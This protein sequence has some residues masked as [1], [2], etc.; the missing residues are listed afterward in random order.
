MCGICGIYAWDE[1]VRCDEEVVTR[2]RDTLEHRGPDDAGSYVCPRRRVALGHRRLS[3]ID[4][5]SAGHQPMTSEDE[6]V[7]IVFNGEIY[8]HAALRLELEDRGHVFAS[9]TDTEAI[10]HLYEEVGERCVERLD[11]MFALAIWDGRRQ[12]LFLARDR[13]GVKPLYWATVPGGLLFGSEVKAILEHPAVARGLDEDAFADYLTFGFVP[14]PRTL[15]QG[16]FKLAG[17]ERMTIS[18]NGRIRSDRWWNPFSRSVADDVA[19]AT[20]AELVVALRRL[21]SDSIRQRMMSDVP[22]GVFLSGGLDSSTNVALMAELN[23]GPVRT[24]AI[25]PRG[26]DRYDERSAARTVAQRFGTEHHEILL[27]ESELDETLLAMSFHEDEPGADWTA[28]PQHRLSWLARET[29]TIVIQ[30]GEGADELLH[31]YDGYAAHRRFAVP[32]QRIPRVLRAPLGV[33]AGRAT[34]RLGRGVRHGEALRDAGHSSI[35]YWGGSIFYRGETKDRVLSRPLDRDSYR[36]V[37]R[38]WDEASVALPNVDVFQK[39]TYIEL[40]QR[41]P[42]L[43]L[44]RLDRISM[45][46]SIEAREP[47]LD[48]RLVEFCL[49][50]PPR[51]KHREGVGKWAMRQAMRGV[52]PDEIIDRPKQGFGTPMEEWMRGDFGAR[53]QIAVRRSKLSERDLLDYAEVDRLFAAHRAGRGDFSKH[54]WNLYAVSAWYDRWIAG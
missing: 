51:L 5:T 30:C 37:E 11:G 48:H 10:L 6:T 32:F 27:D 46:A 8:N 21:L 15:F 3:I 7:W 22:F 17:A 20:D 24:F 14:P 41:L 1:G 53:A 2:M 16:V 50:L 43:L 39:M 26:H 49:A 13:L 23:E 4:L 44:M 28:L 54:L 35:P 18:S 34:R 36:A 40:Q 9:H 31:G 33:A 25:A 38:H 52:L 12:E 47:F 45:A 42:E 29:G 19:G